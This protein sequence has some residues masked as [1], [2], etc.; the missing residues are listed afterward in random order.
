MNIVRSR[1]LI[2]IFLAMVIGCAP[3]PKSLPPAIS[4]KAVY[5]ILEYPFFKNVDGLEIAAVPYTP[6]QSIFANPSDTAGGQVDTILNILDAGVQPIR[7]IIW[8]KSQDVFTIS[9]DQ[10]FGVADSA[11]YFLYPPED[12]VNLV[13]KSDAFQNALEGSQVGP[14]IGALMGSTEL[15]A[16]AAKSVTGLNI[17]GALEALSE[18][19]NAYA[20]QLTRLI[21]KI[22]NETALTE[23]TL[24]PEYLVHGVVFLPSHSEIKALRIV[25]AVPEKQRSVVIEIDFG[26][27]LP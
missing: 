24:Y 12:A 21:S 10:I 22:F 8:N 25:G 6:G 4:P 26:E 11:V 2:L 23:S 9:P 16:D 3:T 18:P 7:L 20:I 27:A 17:G 14:M 19:A 1:S 5:P 13:G 15:L